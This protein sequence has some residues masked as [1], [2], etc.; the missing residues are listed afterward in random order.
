[1]LETKREKRRG[2]GGSRAG[3]VHLNLYTKHTLPEH[4]VPDGVVNEVNSRLTRVDHETVGELHGL[5]A[6]GTELSRDNDF[7]A[8]GTGL[9]DKTEDTVASPND[10]C[11]IAK[12]GLIELQRYLRTARPLRSLYLKLS[13]WAIA[14]RPRY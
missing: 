5:G 9:H 10:G 8:L 7:T 12:R 1:M 3:H 13:H 2:L 4:D 11:S 6:G 14:E